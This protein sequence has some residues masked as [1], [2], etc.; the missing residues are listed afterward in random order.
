[1]VFGSMAKADTAVSCF[2]EASVPEEEC[3]SLFLLFLAASGKVP[4]GGPEGREEAEVDFAPGLESLDLLSLG[5][6]EDALEGFADE[7]VGDEAPVAGA[8]EILVTPGTSWL[9]EAF[10]TGGM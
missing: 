9:E 5:S 2:L 1:M 3:R 4:P 6:R 8:C 7:T 10:L